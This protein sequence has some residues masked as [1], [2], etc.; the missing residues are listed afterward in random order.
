M[1]LEKRG[2]PE[3]GRGVEPSTKPEIPT[4]RH[5]NAKDTFRE[6][7]R[8]VTSR[9]R[10]PHLNSYSGTGGADTNPQRANAPI[11]SRFNSR[12]RSRESGRQ[13]EIRANSP[14]VLPE[15]TSR[16]AANVEIPIGARSAR[17]NRSPGPRRREKRPT[18][19]R[20]VETRDGG[21]SV[22]TNPDSGTLPSWERVRALNLPNF[23]AGPGSILWTRD[24]HVGARVYAARRPTP[25]LSHR[26]G[27]VEPAR[28]RIRAPTRKVGRQAARLS[29]RS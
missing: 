28:S 27:R 1:K 12:Q 23:A 6:R 16:R 17:G 26:T 14:P 8:D 15:A 3:G 10:A 24:T 7:S 13:S 29:S 2:K 21:G 20:N 18:K 9:R 22:R 19:R 11:D 4:S 5:S 25:P